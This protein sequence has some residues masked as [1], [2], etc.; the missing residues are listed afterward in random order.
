MK[1]E[2]LFMKVKALFPKLEA[3]FMKVK[4]LF[5]KVETVFMKVKTLFPKLETVFSIND[6]GKVKYGTLLCRRNGLAKWRLQ[7]RQFNCH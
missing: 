4:A 2:S 3:V 1:V 6:L 7:H 5:P